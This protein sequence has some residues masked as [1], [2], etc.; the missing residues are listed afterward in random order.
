VEAYLERCELK[1]GKLFEAACRLGGGSGEYGL[2]LGL[3]FQIADDVLDADVDEATAGKSVGHDLQEGKLTLPVLL[4]CEADPALGK[5]VRGQLGEK[6]VPADVAAEILVETR[7]A[8][9]VERARERARAL[10]ADAVVELGALPPS[11]FRDALRD[12]A[13]LSVERKA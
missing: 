9:G 8:G 11:P 13:V 1:T 2:A 5:R 7:K 3:A 6:G 4:A 10:A 12:L